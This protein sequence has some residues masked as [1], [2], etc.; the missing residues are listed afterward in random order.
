M[1][2]PTAEQC[3][4]FLKLSKSNKFHLWSSNVGALRRSL[5][6]ND[7]EGC[8]R[9]LRG[10]SKII[11]ADIG[12]T[13]TDGDT[14]EWEGQYLWAQYRLE[15]GKIEGLRSRYYRNGNVAEEQTYRN[16]KLEGASRTFYRDGG[17]CRVETYKNGVSD[18]VSSM[19]R[20]DGSLCSSIPM[21]KGRRHGNECT[22]DTQGRLV[23]KET[24]KNGLLVSTTKFY[25]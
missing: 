17:L 10:F 22:L 1:T 4:H 13:P 23:L 16:D 11:Q 25:F 21:K 7:L 15:N 18:G 3:Q 2:T 14:E 8:E 12:Y 9:V 5:K 20:Q 19:Y 6:D 24:Y